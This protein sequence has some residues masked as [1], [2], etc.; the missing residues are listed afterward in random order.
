MNNKITYTY[1]D[2][3][4]LIQ[5]IMISLLMVSCNNSVENPMKIN[6]MPKIYPDYI[7]VTIPSDIA[8]MDFN[9]AEEE[10]E[11]MDVVA[12]GSK[13]GEIHT[14]GDY[15]DFNIDEWHKLTEQNINGDII[16][17]VCIKK[18]GKWNQY[19]DFPIHVS[20]Y[21]LDAYGLTYRR[22]P[23]GYEVG[24]N[25]G[26]YQR[27]IHDFNESALLKETAVPGLCMNCHT[28]NRTDPKTF[29]LHI[30]AKVNGGTLIQKNGKQE[31]FN[32]KT[33]STVAGFCYSYW[34]PSGNYCA[35]SVNK[36]LQ[37]FFVGKD[38]SIEVYDAVSDVLIYDTRANEIILS[39]LLQTKDFE[40]YPAFSP[41]GST[42]YFCTSKCYNLPAEYKKVK[43]SLCSIHF[44]AQSGKYGT[45][46]DT[47]INSRILNKSITFPRPSYDGK[48]LMYNVTEYG[49][50]PVNHREADLWLMDIKTGKT[51]PISEANSNDAE[52]FH[53]WSADSHWFV[54][55]SRRENGMYSMLFIASIDEKGHVTKPFLL[56]QRNPREFYR[57]MMDSYNCPDFTKT[58]V[59]FNPRTAHYI[60]FSGKRTQVKIRKTK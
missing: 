29:T 37:S 55:S 25:I 17:T 6:K 43:Y 33:D 30:R 57:D 28:S 50:F 48:W 5:C 53:N 14:N 52:S 54:F 49:N 10:I 11:G 56:P 46:V 21:K 18:D 23:P 31:W 1:I 42:L 8:P 44:D 59:E 19:K 51:R 41:N 47:L 60:V 38:K 20:K 34:H 7:D 36:V 12:K 26:I 22:I 32:T 24:G 27:D 2:I 3:R 45:K 35:Y 16:F 39:P 15:A 9:F 58:K 4:H 40:T 13:G